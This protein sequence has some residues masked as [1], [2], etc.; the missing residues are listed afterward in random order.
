M[1]ILEGGQLELVEGRAADG[2]RHT[3]DKTDR[4]E[5]ELDFHDD[6]G[7]VFRLEVELENDRFKVNSD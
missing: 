2:W 5:I 3:V 4:D 6:A 1:R 7:G